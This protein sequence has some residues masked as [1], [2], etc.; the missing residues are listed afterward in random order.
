MTLRQLRLHLEQLLGRDLNEWKDV[1]RQVAADFAAGRYSGAPTADVATDFAAHST[2]DPCADSRYSGSR[3]SDSRYNA[4]SA[5]DGR[6]DRSGPQPGVN[7]S[8][9]EVD[10]PQRSLTRGVSNGSGVNSCGSVHNGPVETSRATGTTV[11]L[12]V[13]SSGSSSINSL[14]CE[15][16]PRG[17]NGSEQEEIDFLSIR[18]GVLF[19]QRALRRRKWRIL[20]SQ[21]IPIIDGP[22]GMRAYPIYLG[23][24][25]VGTEG[26]ISG[27]Q[28][29]H[30]A[31]CCIGPAHPLRMAAIFLVEW[32]W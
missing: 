2:V 31:C 16:P 20:L 13:N 7:G 23:S 26:P 5:D 28:Y 22:F 10:G 4:A 1:I 3:S 8:R 12:G 30:V 21:K 25:R 27:R 17:V 15:E 29:R 9:C 32:P 18:S 11:A 14:A 6:G 24:V 19:L